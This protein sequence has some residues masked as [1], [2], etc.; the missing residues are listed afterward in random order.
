MLP[1]NIHSLIVHHQSYTG[2]ASGGGMLVN[3]GQAKIFTA[4]VLLPSRKLRISSAS[5]TKHL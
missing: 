2:Y 4:P 5:L 1:H 3:S